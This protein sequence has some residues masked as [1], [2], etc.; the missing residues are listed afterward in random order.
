[1][2]GYVLQTTDIYIEWLH[3]NRLIYLQQYL[4]AGNLEVNIIGLFDK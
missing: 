1:M 4:I 3:L 2:K